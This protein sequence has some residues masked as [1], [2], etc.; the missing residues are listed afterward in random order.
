MTENFRVNFLGFTNPYDVPTTFEGAQPFE[1]RT[2][3]EAETY[4]DGSVSVAVVYAG[5]FSGPGALT[6]ERWYFV[7]EDGYAK[8]DNIAGALLPEG[9]LPGATVVDVQMVDYAFALSAYTVPADAPVIFRTTNASGTGAPHLNAVLQLV[10]GATA[11]AV[12][13][14][15]V[16]LE[17]EG[18][19]TGDFG[20]VFL[21]PGGIGDLAFES[22]AAGT[23]FLV[24]FVDTEDGTPH[25]ELGM[26]TQITVE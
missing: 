14:G 5:F 18:T 1:I 10:E 24:C 21:E 4:D 16:D 7:E 12:I 2:V 22:L 19:V 17:A 15:E 8:L 26:V 11:E 3:G 20:T 25:F 9:A 13:E 23:Y 6:S